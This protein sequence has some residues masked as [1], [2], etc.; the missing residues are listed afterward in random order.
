MIEDKMTSRHCDI[1]QSSPY[2]AKTKTLRLLNGI[3]GTR[4]RQI[5]YICLPKKKTQQESWGQDYQQC[6]EK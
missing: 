3:Y 2:K 4:N 1:N 6:N 5:L